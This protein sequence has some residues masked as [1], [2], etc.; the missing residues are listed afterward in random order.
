MIDFLN[1]LVQTIFFLDVPDWGDGRKSATCHD[2]LEAP[3]HWN[4]SSILKNLFV[5]GAELFE[6]VNRRD[7]FKK[8]NHKL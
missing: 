3:S 8:L 4:L 1:S 2:P 6:C 7:C 5:L